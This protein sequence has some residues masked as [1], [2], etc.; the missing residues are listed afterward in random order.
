MFGLMFLKHYLNISDKKLIE[1]FNTDWSLQFFCGKVLADNQQV[2]DVNLPSRVRAYIAEYADLNE[3]QQVLLSHWKADMD[4]THVLFMDATCYESYIRYPTDIRLLWESNQWIYEK[5]LFKLCK[6]TS[7]RRPRN[8]F[9]DQK[10]KQLVYDRLRRKSH[11]KGLV[12]KRSLLYLLEK[13]LG[14]LQ[15][16][17]DENPSIVLTKEQYFRIKTIR[18]V[19]TQQQYLFQNPGGKV[20]DRIVSLHKPYLRPIVRG[21]ENKPVEFGMKAHMLQCDGITYF[22]NMSFDAFNECKRLKISTL[23]HKQH[24]GQLHQVAADRIYPTNENR[25]FLTK[26]SIFTNFVKKGSGKFSKA[27]K[28]LQIVLNKV[29]STVLEGSFGNHKNHYGLKKVKARGKQNERVWVF[30]GVMATNAVVM[31][32]KKAPPQTAIAA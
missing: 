17:L 23:K 16:V 4:N 28:Q 26:Q 12:R 25:R 15:E 8:K 19:L 22:D 2:K 10:R 14:L 7:R 24:F 6:L 31:I 9:L 18:R 30:F 13:S 5:L 20:S 1:R 32:H 11:K 29:R 21:K 3:I 27:E